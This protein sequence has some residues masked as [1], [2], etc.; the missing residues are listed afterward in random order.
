MRL[1]W[2]KLEN[3]SGHEVGRAL[4]ARLWQEE[5]GREMPAI[6]KTDRGK[7]F[8]VGESYYFSIS[9]T[10]THAF[11]CLHTR[12]VGLDAEDIG[13]KPDLRLALRFCSEAEQQRIAASAQPEDALL[14]LWVLK[15]AWAKLTGRGWGDYLKETNFSPDD[16]ALQQIDGC[17]VAVLE[18]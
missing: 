16:P 13:R 6:A 9:H 4:L 2:K 12:N 1:A 17:Y 10:P 7:P 3:K 14:R 11:C 15:E 5:T 8:F 18:E